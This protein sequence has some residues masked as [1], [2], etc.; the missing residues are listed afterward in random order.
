M[1]RVSWLRGTHTR[2]LPRFRAA[3]VEKSMYLGAGFKKGRLREAVAGK[4][5]EIKLGDYADQVIKANGLTAGEEKSQ[6][7]LRLELLK[8]YLA[9]ARKGVLRKLANRVEGTCFQ[10][11]EDAIKLQLVLKKHPNKAIPK[12]AAIEMFEAEAR[13]MKNILGMYSRMPP[14][15]AKIYRDK[16]ADAVSNAKKASVLQEGAV[17]NLKRTDT[18]NWAIENA[19]E[20]I[21]EVFE[22]LPNDTKASFHFIES[23]VNEK[24]AKK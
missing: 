15:E 13:I 2:G 12:K 11:A 7:I 3:T 4:I 18:V 22:L 17:I 14:N 6:A 20:A 1:A 24:L 8:K 23:I 9:E 21:H 16:C 10:F 19:E 5:K